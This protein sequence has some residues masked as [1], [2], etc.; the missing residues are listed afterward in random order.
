MDDH[1][2]KE[3]LKKF[4]RKVAQPVFIVTAKAGESFAGFTAS[5]VT[6]L[7]LNPPL[8]MVGV[9]KGTNSEK[10]M[11]EAKSFAIS[12]LVEGQ[13]W[14][15][16]KM[17]ERV[18]ALEKLSSVG[19]VLINDVPVIKDSQAYVILEK[20]GIW[21][22]GDH[23]VVVGEVIDGVVRDFSKPLVYHEREYTTSC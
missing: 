2:R 18:P 12:I 1:E 20:R 21:D 16:R 7:S 22:I 13:E 5:S 4:M 14:I 17:A 8:F 6:S 10:V 19:Y 9:E 15:A 3:L 11:R 23:I